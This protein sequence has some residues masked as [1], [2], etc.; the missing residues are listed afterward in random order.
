MSNKKRLIIFILLFPFISLFVYG[1]LSYLLLFFNSKKEI[2][3]ELTHYEQNL[4]NLEKNRLK[5]K[6]E[7]LVNFINYYDG[8]SSKKIKD[9]VKKVV[10]TSVQVANNLYHDYKDKLPK[11][12]LQKL[13]TNS[14]KG[15][16]FEGNLGYLFVLDLKGDVYV[17]IDPKMVGTNIFDIKDVNGKYILH[18]FNKV[19]KKSGEG[20]VDY[21]WYIV[22]EDRKRMHYKISY[23]KMLDCY[24]WYVG[25]GEYLKYMK[26][27]VK[28]DILD[29]IRANAKFKN[30]YFYI[31]DSQK[32]VIFK[33]QSISDIELPKVVGG[34]N[35]SSKNIIY[36]KYFKEYDWY[37]SASEDLRE[38]KKTIVE[39]KDIQEKKIGKQKELNLYLL[40]F[41]WSVSIVLSLYL[42]YILNDVFKKY[43]KELANSNDK[44]IFQSRQA[45]IGELFSMIAH[46][47]RQPINKVASI[48]ALLRFSNNDKEL[49]KK[50]VDIEDNLNF[51]SETIDD[52]KT[53]YMPNEDISKVNL[54]QVVEKSIKFFENNL[55]KN[56][57][58]LKTNLED[59]TYKTYQ[60]EILQIMMNLIK[61]SI[62]SLIKSQKSH[63][64]IYIELCKD[65][66]KIILTVEDNGVGIKEE[67]RD[68]VFEP[69]FSTK[70]GSMG[71][72]LYMT[73]MI[74]EKHLNG[75]I[76]YKNL[77]NGIKFS[78][79]LP[80]QK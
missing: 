32:N 67:D 16:K 44:L 9:D 7:Y 22:S 74:I 10:D 30:G 61:N 50:Y 68:R 69:Y 54:K 47:W 80:L 21:Y 45:L 1:L 49:D 19:L 65:E 72:G 56:S 28:E 38:I 8:R 73:K 41:S 57:I 64:V 15:I 12:E 20:Y 53:F 6:V 3:N 18:E 63:K 40:L 79:I 4:M 17:H 71:L 77:K 59:I 31:Y 60:N 2:K 55:Q 62:D 39:K 5:E 34:F 23:V 36:T 76:T 48:I 46:Q 35:I 43:E 66:N 11:K 26:K 75:T 14:L 24:D 78:I 70:K 25:G 27:F 29:Y 42:S 52:F 37:I 13:I 51:M 58:L 33:P